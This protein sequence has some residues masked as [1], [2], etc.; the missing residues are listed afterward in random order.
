MFGKLTVILFCILFISTN[1]FSAGSNKNTHHVIKTLSIKSNGGWDYIAVN[2]QNGEIYVSH[3]NQ[4]N[5]LNSHGDSLGVIENTIGVHGIAFAPKYGKGYTSNGKTADLIIFDLK[6]HQ[7]L[8]H[9]K[10]G[11]KPDAI[12]YDAFTDNII[13]C[14]GKSKDM[15]FVDAKTDQLVSTVPLGGKPET[16][17][18]DEQGKIYVNIED[19]DEVIVVNA[20]TFAI[21]AHWPLHAKSPTGLAIDLKN[22]RLFAG[23]DDKKL[24]VL[25]LENGNLIA[26]ATIGNGCDGVVFDAKEQLI[27]AANGEDG[28]LSIIKEISP[29]IYKSLPLVITAAGARTLTYD[30][31]SECVYLPVADFQKTMKSKDHHRADMVSGSFKV[32]VVG[33]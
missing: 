23:C 28:T 13:V 26:T 6:T 18:S 10:V 3:G 2:P 29:N 12:M 15:S 31:I 32:L 27:Y 33:K 1:A 5:I 21:E 8:G 11:D 25:S 19:K 4:V 9:V 16:A 30:S 22:K 17:V 20:K 14:N 7:V 24:M